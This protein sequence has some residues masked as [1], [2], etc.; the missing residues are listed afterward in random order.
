MEEEELRRLAEAVLAGFAARYGERATFDVDRALCDEL[1]A[2]ARPAAES[3]CLALALDATGDALSLSHHESLTMVSLLGRRAAF[4]DARPTSA[5]LL[6]PC[7]VAGFDDSGFALPATALEALN[8]ACLEGY[9]GGREESVREHAARRAAQALPSFPVA[10]R[11]RALILTGV[12]DSEVLRERVEAF[13]RELHRSDAAACIVDLSALHE[14]SR[15]RAAAVLST[16]EVSRMLGAQCV[17][18]GVAAWEEC[19]RET[20]ADFDLLVCE[21]DF[22]RALRVAL[23]A[24]GVS[25]RPD[26]G[27]K[28]KDLLRGR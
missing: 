8:S 4:L 9:V 21:T 16:D 11:V 12:H 14:P 10:E 6:V 27:R 7:L 18:S 17:F 3:L 24:T 2:E 13:G 1:T 20:G 5:A 19:M 15:R 26:L 25:I 22:E 28:V 23:R